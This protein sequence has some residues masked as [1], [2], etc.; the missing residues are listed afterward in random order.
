MFACGAAGAVTGVAAC[1]GATGGA[2]LA[3]VGLA[4]G[5][6]RLAAGAFEFTGTVAADDE[7]GALETGAVFLV[8]RLD[9]L[10]I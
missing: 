6:G 1:G 8:Q 3:A 2:V 5:F 10:Y 7:L 4:E 9:K